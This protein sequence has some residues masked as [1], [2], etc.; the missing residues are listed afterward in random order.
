VKTHSF[1][2]VDGVDPMTQT[3][4]FVDGTTIYTAQPFLIGSFAT[5]AEIAAKPD[6]FSWISTGNVASFKGAIDELKIYNTALTEGQVG[7]LYND[8]KP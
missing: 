5:D 7:K 3:L 2:A 1:V 6:N 4:A 8:E